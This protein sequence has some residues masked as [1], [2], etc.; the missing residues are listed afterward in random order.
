MR[1]DASR[2]RIMIAPIDGPRPVSET[3]WIGI[4]EVG[5]EDWAEW[6]PDGTKLY[7][8]SNRDG[9]SC[10]WGQRLDPNS[11]R[12]VGEPF[13]IW[14]L[15]GR[16]SYE[17]QGWAAVAR[18]VAMVLSENTGNIWIMSRDSGK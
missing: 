11:H 17:Q 15:H 10:V 8:T 2:A 1:I 6:S 16:A 7:F 12:A 4:A 14:H 13:A 9:N 5:I 3:A 18:R